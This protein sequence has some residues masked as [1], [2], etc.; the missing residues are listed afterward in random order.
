MFQMTVAD[1]FAIR[2]RGLVAT[3]KIES[4]TIRVGDEVTIDGGRTA[5][6]NAIEMFRKILDYANAGD[7][8]GLLLDGVDKE[9]V[10]S[11]MTLTA[12]GGSIAAPHADRRAE[13]ERMR[14]AGLMSDEQVE[15]ALRSP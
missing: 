13:L 11:G 15:Q 5:R 1:V 14:D 2:G 3:G 8:V 7:A 12:G 6:V 9:D 4:G 10:S